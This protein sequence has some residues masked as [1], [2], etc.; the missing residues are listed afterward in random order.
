MQVIVEE[1]IWDFK[2]ESSD[3]D[4]LFQQLEQ[5]VQIKGLLINS[6]IVDEVEVVGDG[7][8]YIMEHIDNVH[9]VEVRLVT[10]KQNCDVILISAEQYMSRALPLIESLVSGFYRN[11]TGETWDSFNQFLEG[12]DWILQ[13][14]SKVEQSCIA[15]Q[16]LDDVL[17]VSLKLQSEINHLAEAL[18]HKDM[19]LIGDI[20]NYEINP[21]LESILSGVRCI[22]ENEK[23]SE[24]INV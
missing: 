13:A 20:I 8:Q 4:R 22:I 14:L 21:L 6:I 7:Y 18:S 17:A 2:N 3:V 16:G 5:H 11:P 24:E 9:Y 15:Y 23:I 10:A 19:T 1:Q 12:V